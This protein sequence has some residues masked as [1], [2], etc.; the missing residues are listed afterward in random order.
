MSWWYVS[1]I[2]C[3]KEIVTFSHRTFTLITQGCLS[4]NAVKTFVRLHGILVLRSTILTVTTN[5]LQSSLSLDV[6]YVD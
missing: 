3:F 1:K 6:Q 2:K 4:A 5:R